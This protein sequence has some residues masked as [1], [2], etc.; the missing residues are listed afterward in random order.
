MQVTY[1]L[2]RHDMY[3]TLWQELIYM[4]VTELVHE[5]RTPSMAQLVRKVWILDDLSKL[6]TVQAPEASELMTEAVIY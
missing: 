6:S 2:V 5:L 3:Q 1:E 4:S